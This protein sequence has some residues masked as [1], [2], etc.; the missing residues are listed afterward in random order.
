M[1][2]LTLQERV[3]AYNA[4]F[5][6]YPNIFYDKGWIMGWWCV[7]NDYRNKTPYYGAYP[8]GYLKRVMSLFPDVD[9]MEWIQTN[10]HIADGHWF[11]HTLPIMQLFAGSLPK[12]DGD[13]IRVDCHEDMA[14]VC[15]N[16]ENLSDYFQPE[17]FKL[18][19]ADP[20]Y[21]AEDAANYGTKMPNRK[22]VL[23]ESSKL[24]V[25]GGFLI[26]LDTVRPM[27]KKTEFRQVGTIGLLRS[28]N[29]RIRTVCI[30]QK[31]EAEV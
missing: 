22:K 17:S 23:A 31:P 3:D 5:P 19:I 2:R 27:Y 14:D 30:F 9:E 15:G 11:A 1:L 6:N 28:T 20:P 26:W 13:Y 25:P 24:L 29:H 12:A 18:I 10:C 21:S 7:G 16:A 4:A 8:P